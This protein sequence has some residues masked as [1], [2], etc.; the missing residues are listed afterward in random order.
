MLCPYRVYPA[1]EQ[2]RTRQNCCYIRFIIEDCKSKLFFEV[3]F[4]KHQNICENQFKRIAL[5]FNGLN[6]SM[7]F[8]AF[9]FYRK[10]DYCCKRI[11][12]LR[13]NVIFA[14]GKNNKSVDS[15]ARDG[16]E[17]NERIICETFLEH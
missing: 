16:F 4:V 10:R 17:E 1:V 3:L 7:L 2:E 9:D 14:S 15:F 6:N 11:E 8:A 12:L 13:K 5:V